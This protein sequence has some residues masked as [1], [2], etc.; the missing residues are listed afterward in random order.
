M[1]QKQVKRLRSLAYNGEPEDTKY[2]YII[3]KHNGKYV[4][5]GAIRCKG[6]R[7]VY[8]NMKKKYKEERRNGMV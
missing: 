8:L 4:N 7:E 2:R 1:N 3:R 6:K 5:T